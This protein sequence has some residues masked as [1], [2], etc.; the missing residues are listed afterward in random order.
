MPEAMPVKK[1]DD[2]ARYFDRDL[3]WLA[4]N[5][6][7]IEEAEDQANPLLE[8][9]KFIAIFASNLDE[10]YMKRIAALRRV[11]DESP[12]KSDSFGFFPGEVCEATEEY[13]AR[14]RGRLY[15]IYDSVVG[16]ELK[17]QRV[18]LKRHAELDDRERARVREFFE[19]A[20]YPV[21]T[22]MAV[23]QGH[24]FPIL[25]SKTLSF[26]VML[27]GDKK[28]HLAILPIPQV[29]PRLFR[30]PESDG[31]A[32]FI[33]TD[34]VIRGHLDAFFKGHEILDSA[35]F[36]VMRDSE[37]DLDA[38]A[39]DDLLYAV[40]K[41]VRKRPRARAVSLEIEHRV[42]DTLLDRLR[43]LIDIGDGATKKIRGYLDLSFLFALPG[44]VSRPALQYP[45]FVPAG[46]TYDDTFR[47]I[48]KGDFLVHLP[49]QSFQPVLDLIQS[50]AE[51][52]Q[53]LAIKMTLYRTTETSGIVRALLRAAENG[54]Q[55]T[56]LVEL[57]A[58]FDE[59]RNISWARELE[60]A[61][62]HVIYGIPSLKI[63]S[64][65]AMV[66][67]RE[68]EGIRRYVHLGTGNYNEA[69]ARLYT[70]I[71][72]FTV[73]EEIARDVS[74]TFNVISGYSQPPH[75]RKV[76][77][78]PHDLKPFFMHLID[79]EI[80]NQRQHGNGLISAKCNALQDR[81]MVDKLYQ[82]ARAGVRM[83]L[84]IRGLCCMV[85]GVKGLSETV[86][87]RSIVGRF[88]EHSRIYL[89]HN[90]GNPRIFLSSADWMKRN[91]DRRIELLFPI[92]NEA[93]KKDLSWLLD[94]YWQDNVKARVLLPDG[95]YA[96]LKRRGEALNVQECL[97]KYYAARKR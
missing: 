45:G 69:T 6:R 82:A 71:G 55:V 90:N 19:T 57:R 63:H 39:V 28:H 34:E 35:V 51:D 8:R 76:V 16:H 48:R 25:P 38:E 50:A 78:A 11:M 79:Q 81:E 88:L 47:R 85:P 27:K 83:K 21:M 86:E 5:E 9:V 95:S 52:K 70:D 3:N 22:P 15:G 56:V 93:L 74:D 33:L 84:L 4:F 13:I 72:F 62:C 36:R 37:L 68:D 14:L 58:R 54:K 49:F 23:D 12:N 77:S 46:M 31:A 75:W 30:L 91:L 7:V 65:L 61:G 41:E 59:E 94:T 43:K 96:R 40:E 24:P 20:L 29:I 32:V 10:F 1:S 64:K 18:F 89:F 44:Q 67:R 73:N 80:E 53:V 60:Q 66:I 97:I 42:S 92:E 26:A 2:G 17:G 87:I